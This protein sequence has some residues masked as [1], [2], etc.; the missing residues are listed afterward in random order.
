MWEQGE[1][2]QGCSTR[3]K[4]LYIHW[5]LYQNDEKVLDQFENTVQSAVFSYQGITNQWD[6]GLKQQ[7]WNIE[8]V[9]LY[10]KSKKVQFAVTM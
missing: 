9:L 2:T 4:R 8:R 6:V 1:I 10:F 5:A 7:E 3:L